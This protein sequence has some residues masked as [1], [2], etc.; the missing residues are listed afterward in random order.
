MSYQFIYD[1]VNE[2]I[3]I[4]ISYGTE[5]TIQNLLNDI[6]KYEEL[7]ENLEVATI[8]TASGKDELGGGVKVGVTLKLINWKVKFADRT[9]WTICKVTGGNL[10]CYDT[11]SQSYVYPLANSDYV[12]ASLTSS[13]SATLQELEAIQFSSFQNGVWVSP[14]DGEAGTTFPIGTREYPSNNFADALS[15][16]SSRGFNTIYLMESFTCNNH[17]LDGLIIIGENIIL[18]TLTLNGS[19]STEGTEFKEMTIKGAFDGNVLLEHC[20]LESVTGFV[21]EARNCILNTSLGLG[22]TSS[23]VALLLD[24]WLGSSIVGG[25][26]I[27][28]MN[29]D[30]CALNIRAH[31]GAIK[32]INKTGAS[33]VAIDFL[34]GRLL[35]DSTITAGTFYVRGVGEI[36]ENNATGITLFDEPLVNPAKIADAVLDE[37]ISEHTVPD[38]F[39]D[40]INF[41]KQVEFGSW[42]MINNQLIF[43]DE[44]SNEIAK[45]NLYN[46]QGELSMEEVTERRKV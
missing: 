20:R 11:S 24:C 40:F 25:Y 2:Y 27:I 36:S 13:S 10:V 15:V 28:D 3:I 37:P 12:M 9:E 30:G 23:D 14:T 32:I 33:K 5:L 26:S 1:K 16:A 17:N 19:C 22:G 31:S 35:L 4:P 29:G 42:K 34:S 46:A 6:R 39:A 45:F 21:G 41:I 44:N 18:T 38:S 8:A 43:Y 7:N